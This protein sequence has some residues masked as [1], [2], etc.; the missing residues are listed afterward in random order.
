MSWGLSNCFLFPYAPVNCNPWWQPPEGNNR[1]FDFPSSNIKSLLEA[2]HCGDKQLIKPAIDPTLLYFTPHCCILPHTAIIPAILVQ[3]QNLCTHPALQQCKGKKMAHF[4][5][6]SKPNPVG[7][8]VGNV[9]WVCGYKWL[10]HYIK[11]T[12]PS[13]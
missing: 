11:A 5:R 12:P 6:W 9:W 4:P 3:K 8:W 2:P 7:A 13:L 1:D 10:V